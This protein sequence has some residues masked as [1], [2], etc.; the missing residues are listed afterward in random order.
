MLGPCV[1]AIAAFLV[2]LACLVA[3][4]RQNRDGQPVFVFQRL[5]VVGDL[6]QIGCSILYAIYSILIGSNRFMKRLEKTDE[7]ECLQTR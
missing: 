5:I 1:V 7:A 2:N 4:D 6:F 3:F